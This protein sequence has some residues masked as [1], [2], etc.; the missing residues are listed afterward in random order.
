MFLAEK[1][2]ESLTA[3]TCADRRKQLLRMTKEEALQTAPVESML[4]RGN[5]STWKHRGS[6]IWSTQS[7]PPCKNDEDMIMFLKGKLVEMMVMIAHHVYRKHIYTGKK[8]NP[9]CWS[10]NGTTWYA[11]KWIIV[12]T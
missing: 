10:E 11:E 5:W 2:D 1:W 9:T 6:H 3:R 7:I 12:L 4:Y 8:A